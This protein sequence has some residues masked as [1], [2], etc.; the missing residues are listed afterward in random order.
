MDR[1]LLTLLGLS[2]LLI[3]LIA[4]YATLTVAGIVTLTTGF[5]WGTWVLLQGFGRSQAQMQP[6]RIWD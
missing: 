6:Q 1:T 3:S 2:I 4:P 5:I